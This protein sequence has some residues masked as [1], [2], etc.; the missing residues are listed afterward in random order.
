MM[1]CIISYLKMA[2]SRLYTSKK[3]RQTL[4]YVE[5]LTLSDAKM[6]NNDSIFDYNPFSAHKTGGDIVYKIL[7]IEPSDTLH[8]TPSVIINKKVRNPPDPNRNIIEEETDAEPD[9]LEEF[10]HLFEQ[11]ELRHQEETHSMRQALKKIKSQSKMAI[12]KRISSLKA[13]DSISGEGSDGT[14][15]ASTSEISL[16]RPIALPL[17]QS[18]VELGANIIRKVK[19]S[20][21]PKQSE[22]V[23][24]ATLLVR[25]MM[26]GPSLDSIAENADNTTIHMVH[27]PNLL[28]RLEYGDSSSSVGGNNASRKHHHH[29]HHGSE[30]K[31]NITLG[32]SIVDLNAT[33][34]NVSSTNISMTSLTCS[35]SSSE[36]DDDNSYDEDNTVV[37]IDADTISM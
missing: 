36:D 18:A 8:R 25:S 5:F 23:G 7:G 31:L 30:N 37:M 17:R 13:M 24:M 26:T 20:K 27:S 19:R 12:T 28:R 29:S 35:E 32:D 33:A 11:E 6:S 22:G 16:L 14:L 1:N 15:R 9:E 21:G 34:S 4:K 3:R 2:I 10:K